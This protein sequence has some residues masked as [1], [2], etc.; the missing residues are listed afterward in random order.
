MIDS[1]KYILLILNVTCYCAREIVKSFMGQKIKHN[2]VPV[3]GLLILNISAAELKSYYV[4]KENVYFKRGSEPH[5]AKHA[6]TTQH[7]VLNEAQKCLTE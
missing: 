5:Y 6:E 4:E 2:N 7:I 3:S 1:A